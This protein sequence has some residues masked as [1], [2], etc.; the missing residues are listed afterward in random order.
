MVRT[1]SL[2]PRFTGYCELDIFVPIITN[3]KAQDQAKNHFSKVIVTRT[4]LYGGNIPIQIAVVP[5]GNKVIRE[6]S[7]IS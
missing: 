2:Q 6:I 5:I 1:T 3:L 4:W 7:L